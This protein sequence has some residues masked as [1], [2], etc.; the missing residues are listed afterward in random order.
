MDSVIFAGYPDPLNKTNDA[1]EYNAVAG[2]NTWAL[3]AARSQVVSTAGKIKNLYVELDAA[4][5]TGDDTYTFTLMYD[6]S[7]SALTCAI[8][9]TATS[10]SDTTHEIDVVAGKLI[11]LRVVSSGSPA[12]TP[13]AQWSMMFSGTTPNESLI[14]GVAAGGTGTR[15]YPITLGSSSNYAA[16]EV[17]IRQII[18]TAG[19]IK[20][21]YADSNAWGGT[22]TYTVTVNYDSAPTALTCSVAD[23]SLT[24]NDTAHSFAVA[25]GHTVSLTIAITSGSPTSATINFGM[26]FVADTDGE[27]I[28]LGGAPITQL[29]DTANTKY[30]ALS[31]SIGGE[32]W[33]ATET[34]EQH[35][36]Q[37]CQLKNLYVLIDGS[38]GGVGKSYDFTV[39]TNTATA[40]TITCQLANTTVNN[41]DTTHTATLANLDNISLQCVPTGT[42]TARRCFWGLVCYIAPVP[43]KSF[44]PHI[45]AH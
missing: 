20:N 5:G 2:G 9:G 39:E 41:S 42:P 21:L 10:A 38:P 35:L 1:T 34:N 40:S 4:P 19:T 26:T 29:L 31:T 44:Y 22:G 45:L 11:C 43:F 6:G 36:G 17:N 37:V 25:A 15:Y 27:G 24:G 28:I 30:N 14:L 13:N 33:N 7:P 16:S 3:A 8:V 12:N 32:A 23:T 18:P